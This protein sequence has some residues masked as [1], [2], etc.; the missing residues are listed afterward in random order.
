MTILVFDIETIPD[1]ERG[2]TLHH[3]DNLSDEEALAALLMLRRIKVGHDFLPHYLQK[4]VAISLVLCQNSKLRLW[5]LGDEKSDEKELIQRFFAG[6][7]KYKPTLV[8]CNG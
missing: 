6:I 8:S 2:R 1:L 7:D 4:V 5:S 3:L